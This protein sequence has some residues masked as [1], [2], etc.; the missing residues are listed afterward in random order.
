MYSDLSSLEEG[1]DINVIN[2]EFILLSN[3]K[4]AHFQGNYVE[5][6]LL[7]KLQRQLALI[8]IL[9]VLSPLKLPVLQDIMT[10]FVIK[11]IG[12]PF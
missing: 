5:E 9:S 6:S 11:V 2:K 4:P 7:L 1:W 8:I 12:S 3:Y 10:S